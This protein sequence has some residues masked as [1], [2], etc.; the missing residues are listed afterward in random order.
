MTHGE[1]MMEINEI[2]H[3]VAMGRM[4]EDYARMRLHILVLDARQS[5]YMEAT[6]DALA[7]IDVTVKK[8]EEKE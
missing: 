3:L 6:Q 2:V 4:G 1:A 7:R 5:G 8:L